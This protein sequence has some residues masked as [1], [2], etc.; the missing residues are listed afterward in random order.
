MVPPE[1]SLQVARRK[2]DKYWKSA[3]LLHTCSK[4]GLRYLQ[5]PATPKLIK[6]ISFIK[7]GG[8]AVWQEAR[9]R[10]ATMW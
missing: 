4:Q 8:S 7:Y 6:M 2:G 1:H 9:R 5:P 3:L 10:W